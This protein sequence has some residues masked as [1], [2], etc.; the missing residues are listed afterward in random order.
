[1]KQIISIFLSLALCIVNITPTVLADE[2]KSGTVFVENVTG[3]IGE[4]TNVSVSI[5]NNPGV[6]S[7]VAEIS[8]DSTALKLTGVNKNADFWGAANM[9]P[10][11]DLNAQPYRIIWYD[12]LAKSDFTEDGTLAELSFEVLKEG[13][14]T[15]ELSVAAGDTFNSSFSAVTFDVANGIIEVNSEA[16][17]IETEKTST[18]TVTTTSSTTP[19][20]TT[21]KAAPTTTKA[22]V[23][24]TKAVSGTPIPSTTTT[25]NNENNTQTT[26][27]GDVNKDGAVDSSDAS[28]V[29]MLYA[30][31]S[32][33]GGEISDEVKAVAD[34]NGDGLVDSS[35]ASLILE[36]YAYVSTGGT[37]TADVF[38]SK[39][40]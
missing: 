33:G 11:G 10:G 6:I 39:S 21:T 7:L 38:F 15:I 18:T 16:T 25:G 1:M 27:V 35:D 37:D 31:V 19:V 40:A 3:I 26:A 24:T 9:T 5:K 22:I 23:S 17:T 30:Q 4:T 36:Y 28:E 8:Y 32:T 2:K 14:H 20:T 12:G 13:S 34:I 29:L